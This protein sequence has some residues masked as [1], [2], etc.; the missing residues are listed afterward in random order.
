[1]VFVTGATG[2]IG[3]F[4]LLELSKKGKQIRAMK[5]KNS[6]LEAVKNLF[7]EFSDLESFQKIDWVESDLLDIPDLEKHF[8][9]VETI[10]HAAASVGFDDRS[11]KQIHEINVK[12]TEN[13]VNLA[14]A[15]TIPNFV[16]ISSI[17]VLDEIPG[18]KIITEKSKFD[19]ERIHSEYAISKKKGEMN[20]WRGSQEGLK[21]LVVHPSVVIG[22]LDG[23]RASE[24]LFQLAGKKKAFATAGLTGYV[25]VRDVAFAMVELVEK[26]KWNEAFILNSGDES[27]LNVF[28]HLRKAK[29]LGE[30]KLVSKGKLKLAKFLSQISRIFGGPYMSQASYHALT[31]NVVYSN[32]KIKKEIGME[33]IPIEE[34][35]D[36]HAKRY[37][38][39]KS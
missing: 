29:N 11:R 17:A 15:K 19:A 20:V 1:M 24:R 32:E 4:L 16:Y 37:E 10:Y 3:S 35:L 18:E 26:N 12:G 30:A 21:V 7:L 6:D 38:K 25:D 33:F 2:L 39:F 14:I 31:G 5:R 8:D 36:F 34:A 28:N 27:F 23:N 13:L 22:S 9:G